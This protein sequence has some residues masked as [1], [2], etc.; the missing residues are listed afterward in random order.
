MNSFEQMRRCDVGHVER[1]I[2][3]QKHD[4]H[5]PEIFDA[6]LA[7]SIV[8]AD[9]VLHLERRP[10]R[11]EGR[12]EQRQVLRRIVEDLMPAALRF[13]QNGE[14]TVAAN[15]DAIDGSIWQATRSFM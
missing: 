4:V 8:S 9:L 3:P 7:Q 1:R 10:S 13:E 5:L 14:R 12:A 2:L 11:F 6:R 15:V